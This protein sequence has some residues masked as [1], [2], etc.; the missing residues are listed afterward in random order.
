LPARA[1]SIPQVS[2]DPKH[3]RLRPKRVDPYSRPSVPR[4]PPSYEDLVEVP[5][6]LVAPRGTIRGRIVGRGR[7]VRGGVFSNANELRT[8]SFGETVSIS[9]AKNLQYTFGYQRLYQTSDLLDTGKENVTGNLATLSLKFQAPPTLRRN[10]HLAVGA[11]LSVA[12]RRDRNARIPDDDKQ[13]DSFWSA[14]DVWT[15]HISVVHLL[16]KRVGLFSHQTEYTQVALASEWF[17][18]HPLRRAYVEFVADDRQDKRFARLGTVL[19]GSLYAN[20]GVEASLGASS[21]LLIALPHVFSG[22]YQEISVAVTR[23]L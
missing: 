19:A 3:E 22:Q 23:K 15:S 21:S 18:H 4:T 12:S 10:T 16:I 2:D 6:S 14:L 9:T 20:A 13:A 7:K 8:V 5:S 11:D 1:R 17:P